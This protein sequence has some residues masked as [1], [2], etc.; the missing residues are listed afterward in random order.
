MRGCCLQATGGGRRVSSN[1]AF[2]AEYEISAEME[3]LIRTA[4]GKRYRDP[5][6]ERAARLIQGRWR[7]YK[8]RVQFE[9]VR[10]EGLHDTPPER[11]AMA[12]ARQLSVGMGGLGASP[13]RALA[14]L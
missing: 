12:H 11:R 4:L 7:H 8:L 3:E 5:R 13:P 1:N 10:S 9:R 2:R 6:Y 14:A